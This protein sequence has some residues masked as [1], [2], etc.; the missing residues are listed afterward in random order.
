M[1]AIKN[2]AGCPPVAELV[3]R[4]VVGQRAGKAFTDGLFLLSDNHDNQNI[5][6]KSNSKKQGKPDEDKRFSD[7]RC[8]DFVV[9]AFPLSGIL[10]QR[11]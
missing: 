9:K 3:V 5:K 4:L 2:R 7:V 8:Q 1:A 11:R 6:E 10:I